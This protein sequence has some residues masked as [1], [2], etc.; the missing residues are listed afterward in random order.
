MIK[1]SLEMD[2]FLEEIL[3][4]PRVLRTTLDSYLKDE[5][6]LRSVARVMEQGGYRLVLLTGMGSSYFAHYP[7]CIY[8]NEHGLSAIM[9]EASELL[10]YY[11][12]LISDQ[13]LVVIVSQSG[14]TVEVKKLL[15]E[16]RGSTSIV[17]LTNDAEN[18]LA[19][20]SDLPLFLYA[21]QECAP[22][23]KT[24][25]ATI[26]ALL[27]LAMYLTSGMDEQGVEGLYTAV[28]AIESFLARWREK[29]DTVFDFLGKVDY[30]SLLGR[31]PSVA[32][33]MAGALIL[34]EAAK[35]RA[36]GMSAGQF[37]HGP[38]EA[39][40]PEF[41][42]IVFAMQGRTRDINLRL[43]Q[44]IAEFGGK[45]V[46][47]GSDEELQGERIFNLRLP[48][49][50]EFYSPLLEIVPIQL[51]SWRIATEKGLQPGKFD[52]AKKVTLYE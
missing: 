51:L 35:M 11:K 4:Q 5:S 18:Y 45:V 36:E 22:A 10:H 40:S 41:A 44:D 38:L 28:E 12:D 17:S 14:E 6:L 20:N 19:T 42:A 1:G 2:Y 24:H 46:I 32:S 9:V 50:D 48:L 31:G 25:T 33:A 30:L 43:A 3:S 16:V 26:A 37:R 23:S 47:I 39:V 8:L 49:L 21:G 13:V 15:G 34:K 27:L 52:K 7:A 29:I